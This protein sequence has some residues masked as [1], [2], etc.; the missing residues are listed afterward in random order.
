MKFAKFEEWMLRYILW[1]FQI[2]ERSSFLNVLYYS[3]LETKVFDKHL[4]IENADFGN[5][6]H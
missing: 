5:G 6:N 3:A 4:Y 1:R 2:R